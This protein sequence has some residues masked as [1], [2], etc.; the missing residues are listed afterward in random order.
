[1]SL[2]LS[3]YIDHSLLK[4]TVRINDVDRLCLEAS[5]ENF[6]AVCVR[7]KYVGAVRSLLNG[8]PVKIATVV[9]FPTGEGTKEMKTS[10]IWEALEMGADEVDMVA[11]ISAIKSG[12]WR[13]LE[14][15][16]KAC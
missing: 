11:D 14:D 8:S 10:E 2:D 9:A 3:S 5:A 13:Q 15:E 12:N 1:M 6:A 4:E 16:I 7:P